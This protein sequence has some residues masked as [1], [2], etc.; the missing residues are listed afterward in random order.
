MKYSKTP[1]EEIGS[2]KT[3]TDKEE[4]KTE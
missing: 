4:G 1:K 3:F 2:E